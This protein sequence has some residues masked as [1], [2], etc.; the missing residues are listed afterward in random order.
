LLLVRV[1]VGL[2]S[3]LRIVLRRSSL[4]LSLGGL[5]CV[6]IHIVVAV[7]VLLSLHPPALLV[8]IAVVPLLVTTLVIAVI[9]VLL[10]VLVILVIVALVPLLLSLL[11]TSLVVVLLLL[12]L[13]RVVAVLLLLVRHGGVVGCSAVQPQMRPIRR[14]ATGG[15]LCANADRLRLRWGEVFLRMCTATLRNLSECM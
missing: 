14:L 15:G 4:T 6:F 11:R 10:V 2:L 12:L 3:R 5:S 9:V 7:V 13:L 1:V 8:I